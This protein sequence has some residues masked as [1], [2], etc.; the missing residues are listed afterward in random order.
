M[1]LDRHALAEELSR[2]YLQQILI[3]GFFHADPHP[4]NVHL[5]DDGRLVLLDL[6][7]VARIS[8]DMQESLVKLLLA[9]SEGRG[10]DAARV[11]LDIAEKRDHHDEAEFA[12]RAA[13]LV[14]RHRD[15]RMDQIQAGRV[16]LELQSFAAD[17]GVR[18]PQEFTMIGKALLNLDLVTRTLDPGFD[19]NASIRRNAVD[20]LQNRMRRKLSPGNFFN[21][22]LEMSQFT[23]RLPDRLNRIM[24]LVAGNKLKVQVDAID[25]DRFI[26]GLQKIANRIAT[27]LVLAALIVGAALIMRVETPFQIFGYP[28]LAILLFVAAAT[29]G[30]V[31]LISILRSDR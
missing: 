10:D 26:Q 20:L 16:I 2:V 22:L 21:S 28:G 23:Q 8:P 14:A 12:R 25:E 5:S 27:G 15:A 17:T 6:G 30:V 31:L 1:E 4:G 18:L 24:E 11:A 19:P 3:D 7:M 29:G 13:E 9:I